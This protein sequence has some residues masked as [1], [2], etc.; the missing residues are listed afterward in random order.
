MDL[1][2]GNLAVWEQFTTNFTAAKDYKRF[3]IDLFYK[4]ASG[5]MWLDDIS[6]LVP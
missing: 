3:N 4:K 1:D 6:L 5:T 2:T